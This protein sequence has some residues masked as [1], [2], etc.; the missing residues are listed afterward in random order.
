MEKDLKPPATSAR[1]IGLTG[2]PGAGK[3]TITGAL[4]AAFLAPYLVRH[5][6]AQGT[7]RDAAADFLARMGLSYISSPGRWDALTTARSR[8]RLVEGVDDDRS[9]AKDRSLYSHSA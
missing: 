6:M 4:V 2:A 3:S 5:G 9:P 7:D 8:A 1:V